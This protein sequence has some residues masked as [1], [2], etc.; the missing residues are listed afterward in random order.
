LPPEPAF[1]PEHALDGSQET[2]WS[3][4]SGRNAQILTIDLDTVSE[5][6]Y[7]SLMFGNEKPSSYTIELSTTGSAWTQVFSQP[8]NT[9]DN[10]FMSF[11]KQPA[12]YARLTLSG[13]E[14]GYTVRE[15]D[16]F[17]DSAADSIALSQ[18][19]AS[20][21]TGG[22]LSLAASILPKGVRNQTVLWASSDESVVKVGRNG[23]LTALKAGRATIT[24]VADADKTKSTSCLVTVSNV[25]VRGVA[26]DAT[27]AQL[28]VGENA[29]LM[30]AVAPNNA[31]GQNIVW[32]SADSKIARVTADGFVTA[33]K[34]GRTKIRAA[35]ATDKTTFA[36]CEVQVGAR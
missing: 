35:S 30:V 21:Q 10:A 20:M 19:S 9:L 8:E 25:P 6:D 23:A 4:A 16:L 28:I 2:A 34:A 36:E 5:V 14:N 17:G 26:L 7:G 32:T 24:A 33:I 11:T 31:T 3:S 13:N 12:R 29:Q 22:E 1:K 27:R 18:T 15:F